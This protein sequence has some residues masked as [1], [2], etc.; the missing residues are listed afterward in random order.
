MKDDRIESLRYLQSELRKLRN[1][2][3]A[4]RQN[5]LAYTI[6]MAYLEVS[7]TIRNNYCLTKYK[8]RA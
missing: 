5:L 1:M 3:V 7:D 2:A 4:E 8:E 6:E